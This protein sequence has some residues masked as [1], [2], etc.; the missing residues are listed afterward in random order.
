V[1]TRAE[2]FGSA[3][4][5]VGLPGGG[6]AAVGWSVR[7]PRDIR[8]QHYGF[9]VIRYGRT[10]ALDTG[11]GRNGIVWTHFRGRFAVAYA[12]VRK[13][14]KLIAAGMAGSG[15]EGENRARVALVRYLLK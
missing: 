15:L 2:K 7:G 13:K 5:V 9:T 12:A 6:I 4:S 8:K 11:F 14:W 10:G 1:I 3:T